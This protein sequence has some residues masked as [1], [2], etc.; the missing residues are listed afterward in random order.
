[1]NKPNAR[2]CLSNE[3][4]SFALQTVLEGGETDY[5]AHFPAGDRNSGP[6]GGRRYQQRI[7]APNPWTPYKPE[8]PSFP[9]RFGV[10]GDKV[11]GND[12]LK[13][14]RY[15]NNGFRSGTYEQG[16]F[17]D[18][19][20]T[21]VAH[22]N[23][24]MELRV[25]DVDKCPNGEISVE[26]FRQ[27]H[28]RQLQRRPVPVCDSGMSVDCAPIDRNHPGRWYLPCRKEP[29]ELEDSTY[30]GDGTMVYDLPADLECDHCVLQWY[31]T[32]AN[33][34]N[35]PDVVAYFEGPDGPKNWQNCEGQAGAVGGY[36]KVQDDCGEIFPEEYVQ[37]ADIRI[38]S[39]SPETPNDV[40]E[41]PSP[42]K[43]PSVT[44]TA[45]QVA[46]STMSSEPTITPLYTQTPY[47]STSVL[48]TTTPFV[49]SSQRPEPS[50]SN[51]I[52]GNGQGNGD[53]RDIVLVGDGVRIMSLHGVNEVDV[54]EFEH[55]TIEAIVREKVSKVSFSFDGDK[56]Y[57]KQQPFY[58][59]GDMNGIPIYRD[60][61]ILNKELT[62]R[63]RAGRDNDKISVWLW[64]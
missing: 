45:S 46:S 31:W 32:T 35:P 52:V 19:G 61:L 11:D 60:D 5:R 33:F 38:T 8:D 58:L 53:V 30:G 44:S 18:V 22:H 26:C 14:G 3:T 36:T 4:C 64:K 57:D 24:F 51:Y 55:V 1:M 16:G 21:I 54:S 15:Y 12:H 7:V 62:L 42:T 47:A 2:G 25:C 10:C 17:I 59:F 39:K 13:G 28:C 37:C 56:F 41:S 20:I 40:T 9:W 49:E 43:T 63:V 6:G 29:D 48:P 27:G 34:C 50:A 23:G